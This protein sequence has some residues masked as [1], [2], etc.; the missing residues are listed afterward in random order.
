M[1][2]DSPEFSVGVA[3]RP[4][5]GRYPT[6]SCKCSSTHFLSPAFTTCYQTQVVNRT[7]FET[8]PVGRQIARLFRRA[9]ARER[10]VGGYYF[11]E[12]SCGGVAA[13]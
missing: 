9:L 5:A 7:R 4:R 1:F 6:R 2:S 13:E 12:R 3:L 8:R 11:T 10:W